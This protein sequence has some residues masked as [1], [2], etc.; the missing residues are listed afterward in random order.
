MGCTPILEHH[1]EC[2]YFVS[3]C[4]ESIITL[5]TIINMNNSFFHFRF[6]CSSVL[7]IHTFDCY[8]INTLGLIKNKV[9]RDDIKTE[10]NFINILII[11]YPGY[12][13]I[14]K[15]YFQ[16]VYFESISHSITW[17]TFDFTSSL[18]VI[19]FFEYLSCYYINT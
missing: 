6:R 5:I 9:H 2:V 8:C 15:H 3:G 1:F 7:L 18:D 16:C 13:P 19:V 14:K 17:I 4:F 10:T 11:K 12:T